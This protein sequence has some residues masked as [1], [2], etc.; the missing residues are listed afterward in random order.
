MFA[1]YILIF[2]GDHGEHI[3]HHTEALPRQ[4]IEFLSFMLMIV[5]MMWPT[6]LKEVTYIYTHSNLEVR[7]FSSLLYIVAYT[8][9]WSAIGYAALAG[10]GMLLPLF[11]NNI[12]PWLFLLAIAMW[13]CSPTKQRLRNACHKHRPLTGGHWKRYFTPMIFGSEQ[14]LVCIGSCLPL[15]FLPYVFSEIHTQVMIFVFVFMLLESF[16]NP[17][18]EVW[19]IKLPLRFIRMLHHRLKLPFANWI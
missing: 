1:W 16:E 2:L 7:L 3:A 8:I 10:L 15:M 14:C 11:S 6:Q 18:R 13:Q 19:S 4:E 12:G 5:A 9:V 17:D